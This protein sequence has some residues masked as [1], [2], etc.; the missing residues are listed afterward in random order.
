MLMPLGERAS[1]MTG[2]NR[3]Q[4]PSCCDDAAHGYFYLGVAAPWSYFYKEVQTSI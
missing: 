1:R 3:V 2:A 4:Q